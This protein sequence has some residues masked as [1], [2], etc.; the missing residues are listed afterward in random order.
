[1]R[2]IETYAEEVVKLFKVF[3]NMLT[4]GCT[5]AH[6]VLFPLGGVRSEGLIRYLYDLDAW[7]R[8]GIVGTML[9]LPLTREKFW[10]IVKAESSKVSTTNTAERR[11]FLPE[12]IS[13]SHKSR[14]VSGSVE[15]LLPSDIASLSEANEKTLITA[16]MTEIKD[17]HAIDVNTFPQLDRCSGDHVF[18]DTMS[19]GT[20]TRIFS[21]GAS[22]VTRIIQ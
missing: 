14:T 8:S 13:N 11:L 4:G 6:V 21:I 16:L 10:E 2:G 19:T 3:T 22:H 9:S 1:M 7:L 5:V 17:R 15:G 20:G 12:T 18:C